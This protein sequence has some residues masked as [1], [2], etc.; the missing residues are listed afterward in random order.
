MRKSQ[1]SKSHDLLAQEAQDAH[2]HEKKNH[3]KIVIK[4]SRCIF[5][6]PTF[7]HEKEDRLGE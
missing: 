3:T 7:I 2:V 1:V 5:P 6:S 4:S